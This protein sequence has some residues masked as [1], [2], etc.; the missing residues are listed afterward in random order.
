M[1]YPI[2]VPKEPPFSEIPQDSLNMERSSRKVY[3]QYCKYSIEIKLYG[4][5][6]G[7]CK[8]YLIDYLTSHFTDGKLA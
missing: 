7:Q 2:K 8:S 3:C 1:N 4:A 5:K 6:C